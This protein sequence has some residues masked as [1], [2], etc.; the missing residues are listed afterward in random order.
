MALIPISGSVL[1]SI[2]RAEPANIERACKYRIINKMALF[3]GKFPITESHNRYPVFYTCF[4]VATLA[5]HI[6]NEGGFIDPRFKIVH[7]QGKL[8]I[9]TA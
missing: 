6:L 2:K 7:V 8:P 3:P 4:T 5:T 1:F 9:G